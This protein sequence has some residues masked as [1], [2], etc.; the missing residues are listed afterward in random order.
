MFWWM[1]FIPLFDP[2]NAVSGER[3]HADEKAKARQGDKL[4]RT[5]A[6]T[7]CKVVSKARSKTPRRKGVARKPAGRKRA[8]RR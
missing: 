5:R 6:K 8:K 4:N 3:Q 2:F 1:H 7:K